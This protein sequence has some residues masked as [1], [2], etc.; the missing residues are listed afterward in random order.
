MVPRQ[1]LEA[2][3]MCL[4]LGIDPN[5]AD[6]DGRT[7]LH[8]AAH[9]GDRKSFNSWRTTALNSTPTTAGAATASTARCSARP[10]FRSIG[11]AA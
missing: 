1:S 4:D 5:I 3:K 10:G 2:V 6:D 8:G 11:H 9:K 7:A